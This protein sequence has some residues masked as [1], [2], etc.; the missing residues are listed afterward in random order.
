M[1]P[2]FLRASLN[3]SRQ[4]AERLLGASLPTDWPH[5]ADLLEM[6]LRQLESDPALLPWLLRA[7]VLR[8]NRTAVGFIGFH[9]APRPDYLRPW[10]PEGVEFGFAVFLMHRRRGYAQEASLA[11]MRWAREERG[12]A[13]FVV[14]VRPDNVASQALVAKLGFVKVGSHVDEIDGIEDVLVLEAR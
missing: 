7:M 6:R 13:S 8:E 1:S 5:A 12:V 9:T 14:S 3:G 2:G 4:S 11:L 10:C